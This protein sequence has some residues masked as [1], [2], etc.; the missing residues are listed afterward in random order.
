MRMM[1]NL[2]RPEYFLPIHGELRHL[3]AHAQLARESGIKGENIMV[4]ENGHVIELDKNGVHVA[5]RVPGGYVF[6]DGNGV[7]DVGRAVLRDR[8]VLAQDGFVMAIIN[9]D[10]R[11]NHLLQDPEI[12]S[13]G[14]VYL[15]DSTDIIDQIR[16]SVVRLS[17]ENRKSSTEALRREVEDGLS[18]LIYLETRR[19]PMIFCVV[20]RF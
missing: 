14:F 11:N 19:R 9:L 5:E 1:I 10:S 6:V 2:T 16:S 3:H 18:A 13:R 15:R 20:N 8:E 7:G 12:I 4:V 17:K